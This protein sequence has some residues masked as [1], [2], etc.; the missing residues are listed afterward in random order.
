[1]SNQVKVTWKIFKYRVQ[2]IRKLKILKEPTKT[3]I[4]TRIVLWCSIL[5][6]TKQDFIIRC[7]KVNNLLNKM[8]LK[9]VEIEIN[10]GKIFGHTLKLFSSDTPENERKK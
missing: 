7:R 1:M 4:C 10:S 5:K 2:F 9:N 3:V 6:E 8:F